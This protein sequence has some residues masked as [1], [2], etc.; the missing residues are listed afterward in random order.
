MI[1]V[2]AVSSKTI[3]FMNKNRFPTSKVNFLFKS[4]YLS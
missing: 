1:D 4:N 2:I 3:P